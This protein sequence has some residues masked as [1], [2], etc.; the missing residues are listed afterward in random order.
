MFSAKRVCFGF[1]FTILMTAPAWAQEAAISGVVRDASGAVLP[2][3]TV[4]A[5]SPVLIEKERVGV[6]DGEGRFALTQLRPGVY[7]VTFSLTGFNTIIR[8]GIVLSAGFN[9]NVTADMRV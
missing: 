5:T 7:K 2:G 1:V 6:T 9:A 3:V 4:T 8:E